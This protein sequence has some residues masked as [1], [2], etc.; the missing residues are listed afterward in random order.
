MSYP[1]KK[2]L[3][4]LLS[5]PQKYLNLEN[6]T[7][8]KILFEPRQINEKG[9]EISLCDG[10]LILKDY[11]IPLELKQSIL[12]K[13]KALK[14]LKNGKKYIN[15]YLGSTCSDYGILAIYNPLISPEYKPF[16][17]EKIII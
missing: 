5:N 11:A 3:K 16:K 17:F 4:A 12:K 15:T 7:L 2:Y 13:E 10:I 8:Q 9:E 14:Q 6:K 1:H